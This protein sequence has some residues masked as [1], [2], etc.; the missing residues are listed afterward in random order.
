MQARY[1]SSLP[2]GLRQKKKISIHTVCVT[3]KHLHTKVI[4]TPLWWSCPCLWPHGSSWWRDPCKTEFCP[5]SPAAVA[6]FPSACEPGWWSSPAASGGSRTKT[7]WRPFG[8]EIE[9]KNQLG[10]KS[11]LNNEWHKRFSWSGVKAEKWHHR[12][13]SSSHS[14]FMF[15]IEMIETISKY[16]NPSTRIRGFIFNYGLKYYRM[17]ISPPPLIMRIMSVSLSCPW[18]CLDRPTMF[19]VSWS[20]FSRFSRMND[21]VSCSCNSRKKTNHS[22]ISLWRH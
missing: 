12:L 5:R 21:S 14:L 2:V 10:Y 6:G 20:L 13:L 4:P 11:S 22:L 7:G 16:F 19:L 18:V 15:I 8:K 9:V 1:S 3:T 17:E